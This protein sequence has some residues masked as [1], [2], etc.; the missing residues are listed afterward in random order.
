MYLD[1]YVV[2][3]LCYRSDY[4]SRVLELNASHQRGIAVIRNT[5]ISFCNT[6]TR[7]QTKSS[8]TTTT[9]T[10]TTATTTA[11]AAAANGSS[12]ALLYEVPYNLVILDEFDAVRHA[13]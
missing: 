4:K 10:T 2:H 11:A 13:R 5:I 9:T 6:P 3:V 8:T 12:S 1:K 7:K